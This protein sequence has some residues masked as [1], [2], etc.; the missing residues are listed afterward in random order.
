[1]KCEKC[2]KKIGGYLPNCDADHSPPMNNTCVCEQAE[3]YDEVM[4]EKGPEKV[5]I[6][7]NWDEA[8]RAQPKSKFYTKTTAIDQDGNIT[9]YTEEVKQPE[10]WNPED[11]LVDLRIRKAP[12]NIGAGLDTSNDKTYSYVLSEN[13]SKSLENHIKVLQLL[14]EFREYLKTNG[15]EGCLK[16]FDVV[17]DPYLKHEN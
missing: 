1:M 11:P 16:H 12:L 7:D 4:T 6:P 17:F 14:C 13:A 2:G 8:P 5:I 15:L 9:T 3:D 10:G